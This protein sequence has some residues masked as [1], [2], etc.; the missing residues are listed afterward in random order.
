[1]ALIIIII[2]LILTANVFGQT[3]K[4]IALDAGIF[5]IPVKQP[6]NILALEQPVDPRT[7]KLGPGDKITIFIWGNIQTQYDLTI[8]PEGKLLIPTIGPVA[9]SGMYL[10][11]AKKTIEK[12]ILERFKNVSV[13]VELSDLRYFRA[14]VGGAVKFPG[15]YTVNGITRVSEI[16]AKAGGFLREVDEVV[17]Q[18]ENIKLDSDIEEKQPVIYPSGIAS[19]RNIIVKHIDG[20]IDTADVLLFEQTG[21]LR[22][23]YKLTDGDEIFIPLREQ[24]VNMYGIFGGVKNPGFFEYSHRDSLKDLIS[25]GHGFTLDVDSSAA[26]LVRF[27]LDGHTIIRDTILLGKYLQDGNQDI[28]MMPDDRIYIK[29]INN[30][31]EKYQALIEGEVKNPGYYAIMP[32]STYL[33]QLIEEAGGFTPLAS[34]AEAKMTRFV[35]I[36]GVDKEFERLKLMS[37][38]NMTDMEYNYFKIKSRE[39]SGRM[40]VNFQELFSGDGKNDIL[41]K[42]GDVITIPG[43]NDIVNV[44][45]EV[46][47]PGFMTFNPAFNYKDYIKLAGGYS[48]RADK[49]K[50]RIITGVT[51]EWKKAKRGT[52]IQPGDIIIVPEKGKSKFFTYVKEALSFTASLATVYLV[53]SEATK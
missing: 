5:N 45:G 28:K 40:S 13:S 52:R 26:E 21:D 22:Y 6:Q 47:N 11:F 16:I 42:N 41:L 9:V 32:E 39:K 18:D 48:F 43:V 33:S 37:V 12:K 8:S 23:N 25:L 1:M 49:G 14:S 10:K 36:S 4:S 46:A 2:S 3:D 51:G 34:L 20:S 35:D 27:G 44:A 30:F 29:T 53:I 17:E 7:Y 19:H 38:S 31:N 50:I 15:I 24:N